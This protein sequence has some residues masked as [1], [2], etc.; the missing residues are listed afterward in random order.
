MIAA[1]GPSRLPRPAREP[2]V[3][4]ETAEDIADDLKFLAKGTAESIVDDA[5]SRVAFSLLLVLMVPV[6]IIVLMI[7]F[8]VIGGLY[9]VVGVPS[10][11]VGSV[12]TI[13]WL[14]ATFV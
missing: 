2:S 8:L 9:S 14:L 4:R 10:G 13:V 11:P 6:G 3:A 1:M 7:S 12:V 5:R